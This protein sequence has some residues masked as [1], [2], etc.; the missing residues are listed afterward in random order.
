[1]I[2]VKNIFDAV[3]EDD[4]V[5]L[6]VELVGL[7][8]DLREWCAVEH[9]MPHLAPDAKLAA[10][11]EEHPDGYDYFRGAY[12]T[13]LSA[14]TFLPS[15]RELAAAAKDGTI[16]LLHQGDDPAHNAGVALYEFLSELQAFSSPQE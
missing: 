3:E 14:S 12:H 15:L 6:W 10:W 2:K 4:G 13:A 7:T 11:F 9:L 8:K 5:R 1:M 16:T